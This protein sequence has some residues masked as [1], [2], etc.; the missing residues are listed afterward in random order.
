MLTLIIACWAGWVCWACSLPAGEA[1]QT[2]PDLSGT[3]AFD[4]QKTMQPG[5][6][7]R[8]VLAAMLGDQFVALQTTT[9]LTLRIK[10]QGEIVVAIYDLTGAD[11]ENLSPGDIRVTSRA[12]WQGKK[13]VI[14]STS[15]G[16]DNGQA[17]TIASKRV[18]WIDQAGDLIIERSGTP[19]SVV[20]P[21]RSVYRRVR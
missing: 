5:P 4:Q 14:D 3:W 19:A 15:Q 1:S 18:I 17:L 10:F 13:L 2:R 16:M 11:S 8:I 7:G 21:S 20:T 12:S 6:D 9:S